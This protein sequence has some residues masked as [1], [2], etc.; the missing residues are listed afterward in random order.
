MLSEIGT[1]R[2]QFWVQS[3]RESE[4]PDPRAVAEASS[5]LLPTLRSSPSPAASPSRSFLLRRLSL[6]L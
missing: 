1:P 6:A 2:V 5:C 4:V 3:P